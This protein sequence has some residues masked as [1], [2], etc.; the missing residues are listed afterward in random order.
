MFG[1]GLETSLSIPAAYV[2]AVAAFTFM[3]DWR[4]HVRF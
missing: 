1:L 3:L 4:L 2:H